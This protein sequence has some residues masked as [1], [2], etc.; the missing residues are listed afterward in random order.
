MGLLKAGNSLYIVL[1]AD[2]YSAENAAKVTWSLKV[3]GTNPGLKLSGKKGE[4]VILYSDSLKDPKGKNGAFTA[5]VTAKDSS[6]TSSV[7]FTGTVGAVPVI[8]T[9]KLP[10]YSVGSGKNYKAKIELKSGTY[11]V[12]WKIGSRGWYDYVQYACSQCLYT[13]KKS[14]ACYSAYNFEY[15]TASCRNESSGRSNFLIRSA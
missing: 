4:Y 3:E 11:P 6:K 2:D 1:A 5:T 8:K 10:K 7:T 9:T 12:T 14:Q 13:C 15:C